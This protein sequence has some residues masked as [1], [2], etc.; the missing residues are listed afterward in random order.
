M[1]NLTLSLVRC[2]DSL[3]TQT[4]NIKGYRMQSWISKLTAAVLV[5]PAVLS[6]CIIRTNGAYATG[7]TYGTV[8]T[9]QPA[10]MSALQIGSAT[11]NFGTINMG[12][13]FQP[14][15]TSVNVTS[16][17]AIDARQLGIGPG[18]IGWVTRQPDWVVNFSGTTGNLRFFVTGNT[19]TTLIVNAANGQWACNDDSFSTTSPTVDIPGAGPGHYDVWVG[20]YSQGNPAQAMLHVTELNNHP[21]PGNGQMVCAN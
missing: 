2:G 17:G 12:P 13:G 16:G 7:A 14:D 5:G 15:P 20:S 4:L 18:C 8:N 21:C 19:D 9:A 10:Y 11:P 3:N 6:G 1:K